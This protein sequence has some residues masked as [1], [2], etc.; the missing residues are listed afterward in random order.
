MVPVT[1]HRAKWVVPVSSPLVEDGAVAV[2]GD[3]IL[4]VGRTADLGRQFSGPVIDHGDGALL[5]AL[6]NA[7]VHLE[8][9]A[10]KGRLA[11]T[12]NLGAWLEAALA[13]YMELSP[14]EIDQGIENG[15]AELRRFGTILVGEVSNTGQSLLSLGASGLDFHYFYECLGFH[16]LQPG[17]LEDDFPIFRTSQAFSRTNFSAAAHA[18]Y[19]VSEALF[20]RVRNWNARHTRPGTVHL[21]ES[22]E[23]A[24][25]LREGNGFF[26]ELLERRGRW[27]DNYHPPGCS[28]A[29]FLDRLGFLQPDTLAVHGL[30]LDSDD[31]AILARRQTWLV[32]CPRS[33]R[34]TGAGFPD[35]P[36]LH[37]AGV[38]LALGTDSLAGNDDLNLFREMWCLHERFPDFP[39]PE[40]L[41]WGTLN[42]A[43]ALNRAANLG[44]LDPG[45]K[46]ALLFIPVEARRHFWP[47]LLQAGAAGHISWISP[48]PKEEPGGH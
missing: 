6:V 30:W 7:H 9:S 15:S 43:C 10:L 44:S 21:A 36:S 2:A 23:E 34:F 48:G 31:L 3:R 40:I 24:R 14:E 20:L 22:R 8:F 28:P 5:P 45:K 18:P 12:D 25:F 32:L 16:L 26:R 11:P 38:R 27:P 17:P 1:V 37:E 39:I 46:A 4:A 33:N 29:M 13:G 35:L 19:S 47:E 41:A 42:G